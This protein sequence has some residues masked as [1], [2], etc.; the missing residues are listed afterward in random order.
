MTVADAARIDYESATAHTITVRAADAGGA[1]GADQSFT[2]AVTNAA[3][4]TPVDTDGAAGGSIAENAALYD[5]VGITVAS[6]DPNGGTVTYSLVNNAGGRFAITNLGVVVVVNPDLI[7][8]ES[9][10]SHTIV[11]RAKDAAGLYIDQTFTIAV[12]DIAPSTPT[13]IGRRGRRHDQR[14]SRLP[15]PRS[16]SRRSPRTSTAAASPTA[17]PTMPATCSRSTR[18]RRG[19]GRER[20]DRQSGQRAVARL[21]RHRQ[22]DRRE[23]LDVADLHHHGEQCRTDDAGRQ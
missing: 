13:D 5:P 4:T 17:S 7:D 8:Y 12:A 2:I 11:V 6:S 9:N 14:G 18:D 15:A 1:H 22:G 3:P 21:F 23:R 20:P 16:A 10:A 19:D